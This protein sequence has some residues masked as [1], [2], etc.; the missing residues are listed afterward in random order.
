MAK[1]WQVT[2][3]ANVSPVLSSLP[4]LRRFIMMAS[5]PLMVGAPIIPI[6]NSRLAI[7]ALW[8]P[9]PRPPSRAAV[10][11]II[12]GPILAQIGLVEYHVVAT[13]TAA[14]IHRPVLAF[15]FQT[16]RTTEASTVRGSLGVS[17]Q[18]PAIRKLGDLN[19]RTVSS[20]ACSGYPWYPLTL[21]EKSTWM[22]WSSI[23]TPCILK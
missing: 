2:Y 3:D 16:R 22:R 23:K 8:A 17:R 5:A 19:Y 11:T 15:L 18:A 6:I 21:C 20:S 1:V 13:R 14:G 12:A 10:R 4:P 9:A 7:R